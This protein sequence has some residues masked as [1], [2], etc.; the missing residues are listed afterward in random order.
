MVNGGTWKPSSSER[1]KKLADSCEVTNLSL[2]SGSG[3]AAV[4][5]Y[6]GTSD[7]DAIPA[8]LKWFLDASTQDADNEIFEGL[9]FT[10]GIYAVC[11]Q[12]YDFS[13]VVC[14]AA[15]RYNV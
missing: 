15:N 2:K 10:K 13:P 11:E 3:A 8:N 6:D 4:A 9:V 5:I 14:F 12:G 1:A 7:Q